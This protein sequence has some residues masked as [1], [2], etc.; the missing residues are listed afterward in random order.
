MPI[1]VYPVVSA[2]VN[3][4]NTVAYT[5]VYSFSNWLTGVPAKLLDRHKLLKRLYNMAFN[6]SATFINDETAENG[7]WVD[8]FEGARLLIA[9]AENP[10]YKA[11]LA[12]QA[13]ANKIKLDGDPHPDTVRLT[14]KIT[15]RAM[16]D[17]ILL[18]W[19][20]ITLD[21]GSEFQYSKANAFEAL[22][23]S[24]QLRDFVSDQANSATLF[25][26]VT[27]DDVGK[28]STGNSDGHLI[29]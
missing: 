22:L 6:L 12:K 13:R 21:D 10:K 5:L 1:L 18:N 25:Q 19:E 3:T 9:S 27:P 16:A 14:T 4:A 2:L 7:V 11:A 28:H 15:C 26:G 20:G 23:K 24:P 17:H 8:F 29:A